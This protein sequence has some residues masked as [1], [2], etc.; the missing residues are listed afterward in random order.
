MAPQISDF[1]LAIDLHD[2]SWE[3]T[4]GGT[5][6]YMAP[7]QMAASC[8]IGAGIDVD[9]RA[10]DLLTHRMPR[11]ELAATLSTALLPWGS[12][13]RC[14][15]PPLT[16]SPPPLCSLTHAEAVAAQG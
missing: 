14:V 16:H 12:R 10:P 3:H 5:Q 6:V 4:G 15:R 8:L 13:M 11:N 1:G 7:E 9:V 2:P